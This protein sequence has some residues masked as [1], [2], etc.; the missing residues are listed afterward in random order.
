MYAHVDRL[1]GRLWL[2]ATLVGLTV[3]ALVCLW[4]LLGVISTLAGRGTCQEN[5]SPLG[6]RRRWLGD[7]P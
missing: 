6:K 7:G 2:V 3:A 5:V 4:R 1:R